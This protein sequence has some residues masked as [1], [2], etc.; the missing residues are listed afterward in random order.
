MLP[1]GGQRGTTFRAT[2]AGNDLD[3]ITGFISTGPGV[4]AKVVAP[5]EGRTTPAL[6][7][8][9]APDAPLGKTEVRVYDR[10]GASNPKFFWVGQFREM[11][12]TEPNDS[13]SQAQH[14]ELPVTINGQVGQ[15]SDIDSYTFTLKKGQEVSIEIQSLRLLGELGNT[16]LKGYAWAED[17]SGNLLAENDGYYRWDPYLQFVAPRDGE[18]TVS[19]RD[20]QY[21]GN[22][23]GVYRLTVGVIPHIWASLPM[24]GQRGTT[25]TVRLL[26]CNLGAEAQKEVV[27]AP[28]APEGLRE[29]RF[30]VNGVWTNYQRFAVSR[31]PNFVE[32]EPNNDAAHAN[33][34]TGPVE[35]H[36]ILEQPGDSDWFRFTAKKGERLVMETLSRYAEMP[37][38]TYLIL[39]KADGTI[40]TENDDGPDPDRDDNRNR[41]SR[42]DRTFDEDGD[43]LI[44]VKDVDDRGG[45]AFVYRLSLTPP[46]PDFVLQAQKDSLT[47]K[48]GA[49]VTVDLN[50]TRRD[51]FDGDVVVKVEGLPQ[52]VTAQPL[53]IAKGQN[54]G[55][56]TLDC[57]AGTAHQPIILRVWGEVTI[58]GKP[59][60]RLGN[61]LETYNTQGTAYRRDLVGPVLVVG[62]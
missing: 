59:E 7:V 37:A 56:L 51:G 28:D 21:R 17:S 54:A 53:T 38:D 45:P 41:D 40:I 26:G 19:Y 43:Y 24:G 3:K 39:R 58:D 9:V 48:P 46:R 42:L 33:P 31:Y 1:C 34:V 52:G 57:A 23:M 10:T 4:T 8:T 5:E 2:I 36:G 32:Q 49:S 25:T 50:M 29:E 27:I 44:Q 13:R 60:R 35:I 12:E 47:V 18:Y 15:N 16:W 30:N 61:T 55:K 20:I 22:P 62:E 11:T 14:I 6:E